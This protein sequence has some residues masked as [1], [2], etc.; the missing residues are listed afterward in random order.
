MSSFSQNTSLNIEQ[1]NGSPS[2]FLNDGSLLVSAVTPE[3]KVICFNL[4]LV[5]MRS[6]VQG[7]VAKLIDV[8]KVPLGQ[9]WSVA[10]NFVRQLIFDFE[11]NLL[12]I[13]WGQGAPLKKRHKL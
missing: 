4:K 5:G 3:G 1:W 7:E 2:E 6:G 9:D 10:E 13:H 8:S 11:I 12:L